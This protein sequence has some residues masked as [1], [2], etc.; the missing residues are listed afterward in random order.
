MRELRDGVHENVSTDPFHVLLYDTKTTTDKSE[1]QTL[2]SNTYVWYVFIYFFFF[3]L[4]RILF[5]I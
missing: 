5:F 1:W 4:M 3:S 2:L